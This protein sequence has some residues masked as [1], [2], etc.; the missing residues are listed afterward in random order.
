MTRAARSVLIFGIYIIASG[1]VLLVFPEAMTTFMGI[2]AP[3]DG[4]A[5]LFGAMAVWLG[6]YYVVCGQSDARGFIQA[7]V[8]LR[9]T[10][11]PTLVVLVLLGEFPVGVVGMGVADLLGAVWTFLA[12]RADQRDPRFA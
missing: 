5:R 7:T 6:I 2:P 11:L 12:M 4:W 10:V 8:H 3:L 9:P 1:S